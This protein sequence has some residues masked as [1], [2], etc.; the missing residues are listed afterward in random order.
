[1]NIFEDGQVIWCIEAIDGSAS[2]LAEPWQ[3]KVWGVNPGGKFILLA[4]V[5]S[6]SR[7]DIYP[8]DFD[9]QKCFTT[10]EEADT[11][12]IAALA[13]AIERNHSQARAWQTQLKLFGER[14]S[15]DRRCVEA[16][17]RLAQLLE[18]GVEALLR[19]N[20]KF[21][22]DGDSILLP[23]GQTI[24]AAISAFQPDTVIF[25]WSKSNFEHGDPRELIHVILTRIWEVAYANW[26]NSLP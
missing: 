15:P 23:T 14:N 6:S 22:I 4:P 7:G 8:I 16:I 24:V 25:R 12:Y 13:S 20:C 5:G 11:G 18:Q 2:S 9:P 3:C 19:H 26:K 1:M 17:A 21:V 10:R